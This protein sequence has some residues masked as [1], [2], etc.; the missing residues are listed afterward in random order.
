MI[1][2]ATELA[3]KEKIHQSITNNVHQK[4]AVIL[5]LHPEILTD[6]ITNTSFMRAHLPNYRAQSLLYTDKSNIQLGQHVNVEKVAHLRA[7]NYRE[8]K[9]NMYG[10]QEV[11]DNDIEQSV[12]EVNMVFRIPDL[13]I[14]NETIPEL[15]IR[16]CSNKKSYND[17]CDVVSSLVLDDVEQ[18]RMNALYRKITDVASKKHMRLFVGYVA[19]YPVTSVGLFL[20][21]IAGIFDLSTKVKYRNKGFATLMLKRALKEAQLDGYEIAALQATSIYNIKLYQRLGFEIIG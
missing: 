18:T 3:D 20:T 2:Q 21:D 4:H 1:M 17:F 15:T 14:E 19:N 11:I 12:D 6:E 8:Q 7:L 13:P 5:T 9:R 16:K 10:S